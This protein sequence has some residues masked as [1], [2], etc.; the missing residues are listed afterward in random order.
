MDSI[1]NDTGAKVQRQ[2]FGCVLSC[3]IVGFAWAKEEIPLSP[4]PGKQVEHD[5]KLTVG[6]RLVGIDDKKNYIVEV[7]ELKPKNQVRIHWIGFES[8]TDADVAPSELYYPVSATRKTRGVASLPKEYQALDK[9]G[10]G[11]IGLYEWARTKYAEFAKLDKNHDGFL[12]PQELTKGNG[13]DAAKQPGGS[14]PASDATP[15]PSNLVAYNDKIGETLTFTVTGKTTGS[16]WGSGPY[17]TD[18][19]LSTAAVHAGAV[20]NGEVGTIKVTLIASPETFMGSEANGIRSNDWPQ[21]F[22]AAYSITK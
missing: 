22:P 11:Q 15:A 14:K 13:G 7:I 9:N 5:A 17:T 2:F 19:E 18:S 1:Y 12:T 6:T 20:K 10:D 4:L 16:V 21:P 3:L 8:A